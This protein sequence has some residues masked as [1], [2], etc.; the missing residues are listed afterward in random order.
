MTRSLGFK[1]LKLKLTE[2]FM[3]LSIFFLSIL[4]FIDFLMEPITLAIF[5][6]CYIMLLLLLRSSVKKFHGKTIFLAVYRIVLHPITNLLILFFI[7]RIG[8]SPYMIFAALIWI[9]TLSLFTSFVAHFWL[10]SLR[11]GKNSFQTVQI[12][13]HTSKSFK[14]N[15]LLGLMTLAVI[16]IIEFSHPIL[17]MMEYS[18]WTV[19]FAILFFYIVFLYL[20]KLDFI[21]LSRDDGRRYCEMGLTEIMEGL[22]LC[23]KD[24]YRDKRIFIK[25]YLPI[26]PLVISQ[27]NNIVEYDH[28][29]LVPHIQDLNLSKKALFASIIEDKPRLKEIREGIKQM[30]RALKVD[31]PIK[32]IN[33]TD[34]I[35]GLCL[36]GGKK[37]DFSNMLETFE[38]RPSLGTSLSKIKVPA[39]VL[40]ITIIFG[41]AAIVITVRSS[42][43]EVGY[44]LVKGN[45]GE[46]IAKWIFPI[47]EAHLTVQHKYVVF[48]LSSWSG[49]DRLKGIGYGEYSFSIKN[50]HNKNIEIENVVIEGPEYITGIADVPDDSYKK[51]L[52][53]VEI[54][55]PTVKSPA[56]RIIYEETSEDVSINLGVEHDL[57]TLRG[58]LEDNPLDDHLI[59][60]GEGVHISV[61]YRILGTNI[62]ENISESVGNFN[63]LFEPD[64]FILES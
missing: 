25:K 3:Q 46:Y 64:F 14:W 15:L 16:R 20:S 11:K 59:V 61:L 23:G 47:G 4:L 21:I 35:K 39:A 52:L 6:P 60:F 42:A 26:L 55:S 1:N 17:P 24:E 54:K 2:N 10:N 38:I 41:V 9:F 51:E 53:K 8:L 19:Y 7:L 49:G 33:F 45:F 37:P 62:R 34:F 13:H 18:F 57:R 43:P 12:Y 63:F 40:I 31:K 56:N 36:I 27:F 29:D 58:Y 5:I 28:P 48:S 30:I 22:K 50:E 44:E 32:K